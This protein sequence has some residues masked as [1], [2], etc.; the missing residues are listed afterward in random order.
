[1]KMDIKKTRRDLTASLINQIWTTISGMLIVLLVPLF[2]TE[3][4]QGYWFLF[5]SFAVL[6]TF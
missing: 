5:G 3:E 2:L 1:M 4:Q 6:Y